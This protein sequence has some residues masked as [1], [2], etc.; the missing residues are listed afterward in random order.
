MDL[1][2]VVDDVALDAARFIALAR[3]CSPRRHFDEGRV[4]AALKRTHNISAWRG[5]ELVGCLRI[6]TDGCFFATVPEM[7]V[8]PEERRRGIGSQLLK[9]AVEATPVPLF[10]GAQPG[11][12][13]FFEKNG[14]ERS[15]Q[16]YVLYKKR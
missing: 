13:A 9:L 14:A 2:Y 12:E 5:D 10:F 8:A 1:R 7:M 15:L 6:L 4:A 11:N 3:R 16:S